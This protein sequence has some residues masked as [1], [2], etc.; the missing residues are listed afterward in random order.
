MSDAKAEA[1]EALGTLFPDAETRT[2]ETEPKED[3]TTEEKVTDDSEK[4][5]ETNT[6]KSDA[7]HWK[8]EARK[9]EARA[10]DNGTATAELTKTTEKL[11]K[12]SKELAEQKKATETA[13]AALTRYKVASKYGISDELTELFLTG[14]D[15]ETLEKQ[16]SAL[17]ERSVRTPKPDRAQGNRNGS[18]A[19]TKVEQF[20]DVMTSLGF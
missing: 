8:A 7:D 15:E 11:E 12:V 3:T 16:A 17:A 9:W 1:I 18:G 2:E 10:K 19:V 5:K 4:E 14:S 13:Q 6:E 20:T